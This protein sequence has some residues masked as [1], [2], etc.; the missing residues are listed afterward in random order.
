MADVV[1]VPQKLTAGGVAPTFHA[2]AADT[3]YYFVNDGET[4]VHVD[5]LVPATSLT[6]TFYTQAV[7]GD[8]TAANLVVTVPAFEERVVGPFRPDV[9]NSEYGRVH[10]GFSSVTNVAV[11]CLAR[12]G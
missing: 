8:F 10:V 9:F 5:N 3:T 1:W 4:I 7:F 2:L 6:V 11:A 12:G